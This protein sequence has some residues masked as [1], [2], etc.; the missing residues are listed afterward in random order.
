[1]RFDAEFALHF[2]PAPSSDWAPRAIACSAL[3][4]RGLPALWNAVREFAEVTR[5]IGSFDE[6]RRGQ[7]R[8]WLLDALDDGLTQLF[9]V[10]PLVRQQIA[11][12]EREVLEGRV[13]P[14]RAAR[15]LLEIYT[16]SSR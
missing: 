2:F 10:H 7:R 3:T 8:R 13:T 6:I 1:M 4:G 15:S 12:F 16:R 11:E 14:F 5:T 9:R